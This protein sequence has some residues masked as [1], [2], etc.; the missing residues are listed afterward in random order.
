MSTH[1][2][3]LGA[4]L[5]VIASYFFNI[6]AEKTRIP[7]VLMLML[8]GFCISLGFD[9]PE[10]NLRPALE[11][12]GTIGVIMIVLEA[13]LDLHV[14]KETWPI[15]WRA[16]VL[17]IGLL[18]ITS[19]FIAGGLVYVLKISWYTGWLYGV[20]LA[21]MS[22]AIIIPSVQRLP[23]FSKEFLIYESAIS[24]I[25]GIILFYALLAMEKSGG[26]TFGF[27]LGQSALFILTLV[28]AFA[29]SYALIFLFQKIQ[30]ELKL[31]MVIAVLTGLY[32]TGKLIHLSSLLIILIFG[33]ILNNIQLFF[34]GKWRNMIEEEK[35]EDE[36][37][38]FKVITLETAFVV[39]TFF[40]VVFGMSIELSG[41]F[42]WSVPILSGI[43]LVG[44]YLFRYIGL[45]SLLPKKVSPEL[46]VAPR[47]LITV[48]L[49]YA[50]PESLQAPEF[51][52][53]ILLLTILASSLIMTF[54]L[55]R[56]GHSAVDPSVATSPPDNMP[57]SPIST[58]GTMKPA[59]DTSVSTLETSPTSPEKD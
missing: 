53:G 1:I 24:D 6:F 12:L 52:K 39:R 18:L 48:L 9:V 59:L 8:L 51:N 31:F 29:V 30:G 40:F 11:V 50:I 45:K 28:I 3:I 41:L 34:P 56:E 33:L 26:M 37:N 27:L 20:P 58:S 14:E 57:E 55:I 22:S 54:G 32:S 38:D 5:V 25:F 42:H 49:F 10:Q 13:A 17:G 35:L 47:G 36:I 46:F 43:A 16:L 15:V 19:F 44:I 4:S 21:V 2:L 7:S 23:E